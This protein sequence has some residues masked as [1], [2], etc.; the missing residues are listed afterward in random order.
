MKF[1]YIKEEFDFNFRIN[2]IGYEKG[3]SFF[4]KNNIDKDAITLNRDKTNKIN[5]SF[6]FDN[7]QLDENIFIFLV[8]F[9]NSI[10]T[11][12][13]NKLFH[14]KK[15]V[16]KLKNENKE[17]EENKII[18]NIKNFSFIN[19]FTLSN[20]PS[21]SIKSIDNKIDISIIKYFINENSFS[22]TLKI[23]DLY[24]ILLDNFTFSPKKK[25]TNLFYI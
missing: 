25:E 24:G 15:Y 18:A 10:K 5:L 4:N 8:I 22:F 9:Y 7:I 16:F 11:K 14:K 12:K 1:N 6:A 13:K 17:N 23:N 21:L 3:K 2:D 19:N 20:I